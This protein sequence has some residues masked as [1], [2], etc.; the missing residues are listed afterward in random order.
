[1]THLRRVFRTLVLLAAWAL[2]TATGCARFR[3]NAETL[4]TAGPLRLTL[5][6]EPDPPRQG[7]NTLRITVRRAD[8]TPVRGARVLLRVSM[9][10]MGA[11]P[12]MESAAQIREDAPGVYRAAYG[13]AM[14]GDWDLTLHIVAARDSADVVAKIS[15]HAPGVA[16]VSVDAG[17]ASEAASP[18][19]AMPSATLRGYAAVTLDAAREQEFGV[20]TAAVA[21]HA[22]APTVRAAGEVRWDES[23]Q[24]DVTLKVA[25]FVRSVRVDA[26][27]RIVRRGEVLCTIYSPELLAAQQEY[28]DALRTPPTSDM[29]RELAAAARRRLVLWDVPDDVLR[30]IARRGTAR[31]E[32]P[33]RAPTAG[34]IV[35]KRA[36]AGS[37]FE[38][39]MPL[40]RLAGADPVWVVANVYQRDMAGIA[41]GA[42]ATVRDPQNAFVATGRVSSFGATLDPNTHTAD[43]RIAVANPRYTLRPGMYVTADISAPR[44]PTLAVPVDA[45]IPAGAQQIV[46]VASSRGRYTPRAVTLGP[47][48]GDWYPVLT[49]VQAG[50]TVVISGNFLV[51]AESR[52]RGGASQGAER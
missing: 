47:R 2:V 52:V 32:I 50:D 19:A 20:R 3:H 16:M 35:E 38:P 42:T 29:G 49:G 48:E 18:A 27:G 43:V 45:V 34:V 31:E 11:M 12:L 10:A 8:G 9:P 24:S 46:F 33:V 44:A 40:F 41:V 5:R 1:M 30:D 21:L 23:R 7:A 25:G 15:T 51:A 37:S 6:A 17:D 13:L 28:I 4:V 22:L 14:G 26:P 36:V 39:G